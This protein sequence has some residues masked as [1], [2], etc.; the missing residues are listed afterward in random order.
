MTISRKTLTGFIYKKSWFVLTVFIMVVV[1]FSGSIIITDR[2]YNNEITFEL[3]EGHT[4]GRTLIRDITCEPNNGKYFI[5]GE[6]TICSIQ[7]KLDNGV[8]EATFSLRNGTQILEK[9]RVSNGVFQFRAPEETIG[10]S[11]DVTAFDQ[12]QELRQFVSGR[13]VDFINPE[14]KEKYEDRLITLY[15]WLLG[16]VFLIPTM[17]NNV[18]KLWN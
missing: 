8:S 14:D 15:I 10:L 6:L 2:V 4:E 5:Y 11:F 13:N 7:P 18:K 3:T 12:N 17:M 1:L 9:Q 16:V